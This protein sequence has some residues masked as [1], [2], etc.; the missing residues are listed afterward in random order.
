[1]KGIR[2][3]TNPR[4][5]RCLINEADNAVAS[6]E[7]RCSPG[8]RA[9]DKLGEP[10]K[11][12]WATPTGTLFLGRHLRL[13]A[14]GVPKPVFFRNPFTFKPLRH[15]R[16]PRLILPTRM[17]RDLPTKTLAKCEFR[18]G[19]QPVGAKLMRGPSMGEWLLSR[20]DA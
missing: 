17:S 18:P 13:E 19:L 3:E 5:I 16:F 1:M 9:K 6:E 10:P 14:N 8:L 4:K 12:L 7:S 11:K 20:R 15:K 2:I